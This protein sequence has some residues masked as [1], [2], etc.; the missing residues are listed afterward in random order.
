M[1]RTRVRVLNANTTVFGA[2]TPHTKSP[3]IIDCGFDPAVR[4]RPPHTS[5]QPRSDPRCTIASALDSLHRQL[6]VASSE[7]R[8]S[9]RPLSLFLHSGPPSCVYFCS[10]SPIPIHRRLSCSGPATIPICAARVRGFSVSLQSGFYVHTLVRPIRLESPCDL[11]TC[12]VR[13]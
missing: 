9:P 1:W 4:F 8:P 3:H 13:L 10:L 6:I 11:F 5:S 12:S 7:A 2:H